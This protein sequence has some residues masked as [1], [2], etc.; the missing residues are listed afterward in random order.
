VTV[1]SDE[2]DQATGWELHEVTCR[3][4]TAAVLVR[5]S[6]LAQ[7][8]IQWR[9]TSAQTCFELGE[10]RAAGQHPGLVPA[11]QAL[12]DSIDEAV[13]DGRLEVADP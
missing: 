11:C 3:R 9:G 2:R 4:C 6:S 12:R 10:R 8:S 7:T 1:P 5:K 13:R